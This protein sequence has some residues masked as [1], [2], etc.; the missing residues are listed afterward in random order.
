MATATPIDFAPPVSDPMMDLA[1][2]F[3]NALEERVRARATAAGTAAGHP[4]LQELTLEVLLTDP[5]LRAFP[6]SRAQRALCRAAD[7]LD[8]DELLSP[9]ETLFHFGQERLAPR[10][11]PRTVVL[12]T[13]VRAGKSLIAALG[14]L[15]SILSCKFRRAP[16]D[17]E[18]PGA[19]GLV[20]VMPGELV[21]ALIVAPLLKLSRAPLHHLIGAMR[22]SSVLA[23][24][25][26]KA[27]AES[28]VIRRPDG[29]EVT[30]ELVAASSGGANL[31]STWLAGVIFDE[32]DF[33][34]DE[35]GAVNL[36][37]N[38]RAAITRMLAGAQIW[39]PSSPWANSGPFHEMFTDAFGRE[40]TS[41]AFHS[42]TRS[43][44]PTLS[45][46]DEENERRRDPDNAARE[47]DA[48]P[49]S[50]NS[51]LFFPEEVMSLA[52][53]ATRP[54]QL[55][56][57]PGTEHYAGGDLGFRKNS[58]ALA[59]AR[60]CGDKVQLAYHEE[61]R[62]EK[63]APLI[64]SAVCKTFGETCARYGARSVRGD[65]WYVDTAREEFNKVKLPGGGSL[66]YEEWAPTPDATS[67]AFSTFKRLIVEGLIDLPDDP[68][69]RLQMKATT[70]YVAAGK[71]LVRLPKQGRSHGDVLMAIVLACAQVAERMQRAGTGIR[72]QPTPK[73]P[74]NRPRFGGGGGGLRFSR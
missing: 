4:K 73:G 64:P 36:P 13:G 69:L 6:A 9:V 7:G 12:R 34:D 62:P 33:H 58:S 28:C 3:A 74:D 32:A 29:A 44:N 59:L 65:N 41:I 10:K 24:M 46:E 21:R 43:M 55:P 15:L 35:A 11:R 51:P 57:I 54:M 53:N 60:L 56:A 20:G 22:A 40:G 70:T 30:V 14:L 25:L 1:D 61:L 68:V 5:E 50:A 63:G 17:G 31:R 42:D 39:I 47:Y 16:E 18:I 45:R 27:G 71:V 2:D 23:P 38:Y 37:D 26:V 19:D 52:F 67:T 8:V 72:P 66:H 49:L 48:I